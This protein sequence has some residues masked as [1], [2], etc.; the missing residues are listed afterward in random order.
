VGDT[1]VPPFREVLEQK[2]GLE[3]EE[4]A[5]GLKALAASPDELGLIPRTCR[6]AIQCSL[7]L[8]L[9]HEHPL[10]ASVGIR[11]THGEQTC[12]PNSHTHKIKKKKKKSQAIASQQA[13]L[14]HPPK[15]AH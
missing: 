2:S 11:H 14:S 15:N 10:L 13:C 7:I 8:V 4:M 1:T 6:A 5:P 9:G 12:R 3:A